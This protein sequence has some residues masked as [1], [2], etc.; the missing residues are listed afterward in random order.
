MVDFLSGKVRK[1]PPSQ[2]PENRYKFLKLQ[3]AEPDLGVAEGIDYILTTDTAGVRTWRNPGDI[4]GFLGS[5]GYTGSQGIQG[6]TGSRG[7]T[8]SAGAAGGEGSIGFTGSQGF[9]GSRGFTGSQGIQGFTGSRGDTG[10]TGSRGDTGFTG[11]QGLQGFT[12]SKGDTGFVGSQGIQ[13]FTGSTGPVAGAN[14]NI[15]YNDSGV[16]AGSNSLTWNKTS[17]TVSIQSNLDFVSPNGSNRIK[18]RM[19]DSDTL[20]F[21]GES[22]QLFSISDDLTGTIFSINDITGIPLIEAD[23]D[24]TIRLAEIDGTVLIGTAIDNGQNKLQVSGNTSISGTLNANNIVVAGDL[25]V[26]GNV[27]YIDTTTVNIGDNIITLNADETGTPT[28]DAGIEIERGTSTNVSFIWDETND[29]WTVGSEIL[30]AGAV[31]IAGYGQVINSS[32]Q[33]TGDP[34]TVRGYTG[35]QGFTGSQGIQGFTGSQGIQG[36]TGS[37]GFTGSQGVIGFTGS[38]GI[39][40]FTGSQGIQGFTGSQG[41]VGSQG[42]TG[43]AGPV[44]GTDGQLVYN[45]GGIAGGTADIT[46]DDVNNDLKFADNAKAVFGTDSDL[47]IS[48]TGSY[49]FIEN[50]TGNLELKA[51]TVNLIGSDFSTLATFYTGNRVELR[52]NDIV[53][54]AT[55]STGAQITGDANILGNASLRNGTTATNIFAHNTYTDASNYERA[56]IGWNTNVLEIGTENLGTG[57]LRN[58]NIIGGNVGINSAAPVQ[59][60]EV[61]GGNVSIDRGQSFGVL[62]LGTFYGI[63]GLNSA[64][65]RVFGDLG[66]NTGTR[67]RLDNPGISLESNNNPITFA[68]GSLGALNATLT[69]SGSF[70]LGTDI[71]TAKLDVVGDIEVNSNVNLNSEATTL[72]TTTKTTNCKFPSSIVPFWKTNCTSL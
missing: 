63:I 46:F 68:N 10:F 60:L 41:F 36:F 52:Y 22:G 48:H 66:S 61:V 9:T 23:A 6:F 34:N 16:S 32:G 13:G 35:S 5:T 50:A 14:T 42:F 43:S 39:Q 72:A 1:T 7:F 25:T 67:V 69:G 64:N 3:D 58:I 54:I 28:Q 40:G 29:R 51:P 12:G 49:G 59:K 38:Q 70:G 4:S 11:S 65:R 27:T 37:R 31:Y 53:R 30:E 15:I 18:L 71:P 55:T 56:K 33:W 21:S 17:N 2:V 62:H 26:S 20:T 57:T 45:N 47:Q 8:G 24:A 44:A 19:L